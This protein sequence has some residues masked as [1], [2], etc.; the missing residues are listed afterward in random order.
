M[1][2]VRAA[3]QQAYLY[4]R[5]RRTRQHTAQIPLLQMAQR[6]ALPAA[7]QNLIQTDAFKHEPAAPRKRLQKQVHL[8]IVAQRLKMAHADHGR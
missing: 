8:R 3:A 2:V 6:Q 4:I 1:L 7:G 5:Q